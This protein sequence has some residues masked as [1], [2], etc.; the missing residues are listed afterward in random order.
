MY[1]GVR[2]GERTAARLG[3]IAGSSQRRFQAMRKF[4]F[5]ALA[6]SFLAV[7]AAAEE[8]K[9]YIGDSKCAAAQGAK[10]ASHDHADCAASCIKAG[11]KAVLVTPEGKVYKLD[12]QAK[13]V[14][15]AGK[16]VTVTGTLKGDTI[17]VDDV[18]I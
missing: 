18:K 9:G 1:G 17:K 15:H 6:M 13:A 4:V 2:R 7:S 3:Y 10:S 12:D 16:K 8:F 14:K 11:A 5:F